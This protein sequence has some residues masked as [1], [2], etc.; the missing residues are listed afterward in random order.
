M[1][2]GECIG[3]GMYSAEPATVRPRLVGS[4][5]VPGQPQPAK[6]GLFI[7][8]ELDLGP[9]IDLHQGL[10][11][12]LRC[13]LSRVWYPSLCPVAGHRSQAK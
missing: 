13:E 6:A 4:E 5:R 1:R 8:W 2:D 3:D 9:Q 12:Q 10:T 7:L 11:A